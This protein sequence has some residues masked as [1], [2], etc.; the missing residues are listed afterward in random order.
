MTISSL[1][2]VSSLCR[3]VRLQDKPHTDC[4]LRQLHSRQSIHRFHRNRQQRRNGTCRLPL[5]EAWTQKNRILK[6][7]PRLPYH[8]GPPQSIL[9]SNEAERPAHGADLCRFF[10]LYYTMCRETLIPSSSD[11]NDR[12]HLQPR[13]DRQRSYGPVP[14]VR[15]PRPAGYQ[16]HRF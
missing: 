8:A 5:K 13:S 11:G 14:A 6:Q 3:S 2:L 7:R 4:A 10:L 1:K 16:H 15:L 9:P 12:D